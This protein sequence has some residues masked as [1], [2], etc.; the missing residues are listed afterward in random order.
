MKSKRRN[1]HVL[2][3][4]R[5]WAVKTEGKKDFNFITFKKAIA[6]KYAR[7]IAFDSKLDL[8]IHNKDGKIQEKDSYES[9]N[10]K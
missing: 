6:L 8:V 9:L 7:K 4:G 3:L 2:P 10:G 5:G 1:L